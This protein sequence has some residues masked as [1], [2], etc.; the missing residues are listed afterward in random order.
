MWSMRI[1]FGVAVLG[2]L[3]AA[4][5]AFQ[6]LMPPVYFAVACVSCSVLIMAARV[7]HQKGLPDA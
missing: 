1:A 3:W 5:P 7:T 6:T 4:L 2:G